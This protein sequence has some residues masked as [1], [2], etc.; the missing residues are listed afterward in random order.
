MNTKVIFGFFNFEQF[1]NDTSTILVEPRK[2]IIDDIRFKLPPNVQLVP[3]LI[4]KESVTS[5][6]VM[7]AYSRINSVCRYTTV[8]PS[9]ANQYV[10]KERVF[11]TNLK[12]IIVDNKIVCINQLVWN[13]A[14][15]DWAECLDTITAYSHIINEICFN[16]LL[17]TF[18]Y[19]SCKFLKDN[20]DANPAEA[21]A[22]SFLNNTTDIGR[23]RI[24]ATLIDNV[25]QNKM[26]EYELL[27]KHYDMTITTSPQTKSLFQSK[28]KYIYEKISEVLEGYFDTSDAP[29]VIMIFN[30]KIMS[31][32]NFG[33]KY[34]ILEDTLYVN[35]DLDLIYS[36]KN[37]MF[38]LY[39]L[40]RSESFVE[41]ME[42]I[43]RQKKEVMFRIFQKRH[44]Y[45]YV[46]RIFNIVNV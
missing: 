28:T 27:Q 38:L 35:R 41:D 33:I 11:T 14:T 45:D 16:R 23:P 37:N 30:P 39:E 36:N 17:T 12:N 44:F 42:S 15:D 3:K 20:F 7:Y 40:I 4:T 1:D 26:A 13:L 9:V 46:G 32:K 43:K 2:A 31:S 10:A 21:S 18:D 29:D 24:S 22:G 34:P 5:E 19:E 25:P 6:K 8:A